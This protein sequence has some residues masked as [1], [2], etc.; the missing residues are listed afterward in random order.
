[1]IRFTIDGLEAHSGLELI[2]QA[3]ADPIKSGP[4]Y[5]ARAV[6]L[7][8]REL[9]D[10]AAALLESYVETPELERAFE[11]LHDALDELPK[12]EPGST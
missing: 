8:A 6:A 2:A 9:V 3:E 11:R 4:L 1:M 5:D 7:Q 10:T 12:P